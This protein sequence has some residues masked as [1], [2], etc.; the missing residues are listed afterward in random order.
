MSSSERT[1]NP[2]AWTERNERDRVTRLYKRVLSALHDTGDPALLADRELQDL[3]ALACKLYADRRRRGVELEAF[4][5]LQE[6]AALTATDGAVAASAVLDA[7]G[8]E[9]FELGM[10][11]TW[12]TT[13]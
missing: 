8:V 9:V 5:P 12:G 13:R 6:D 10:W 4:G 11:R 1:S 2:I 7:V 3:L